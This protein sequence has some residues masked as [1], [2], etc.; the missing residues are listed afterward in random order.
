MN[1]QIGLFATEILTR[2]ADKIKIN[3]TKNRVKTNMHYKCNYCTARV[4]FDTVVA[5]PVTRPRL[6]RRQ[7]SWSVE[8]EVAS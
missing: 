1:V 5:L 2:N 7:K 4:T 8:C 6:S 3:P